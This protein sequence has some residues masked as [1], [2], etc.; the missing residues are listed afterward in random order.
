M[1]KLIPRE[2]T[3]SSGLRKKKIKTKI[4][5]IPKLQ[6]KNDAETGEENQNIKSAYL[7]LVRYFRKA[8]DYSLKEMG[9]LIHTLQKSVISLEKKRMKAMKKERK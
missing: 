5:A 7:H 9:E 8:G 3:Q 1:L 6:Q 2:N 4:L